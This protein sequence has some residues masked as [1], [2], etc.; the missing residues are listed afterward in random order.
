[1]SKISKREEQAIFEDMEY[2]KVLESFTGWQLYG[3]TRKTEAFFLS[4]DGIIE[5]TGIQ[6]DA[7][8][9]HIKRKNAFLLRR[10]NSRNGRN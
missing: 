1:M 4:H 5:I 2:W 3:W 10:R 7:L 6:R 8:V 9:K